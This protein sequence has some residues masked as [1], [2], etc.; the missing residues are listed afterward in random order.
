MIEDIIFWFSL[1]IWNFVYSVIALIIIYATYRVLMSFMLNRATKRELEAH[2]V[3]IMKLIVRII[4]ILVANTTVFQIFSLPINAI[5][6]GS[7]LIGAAIGFGSSQTINNI[8]AGFYVL[9]SQPFK[10]KDYVRIGSLEG[11]VEE[12]SINYTSL[13]TP[14]FNILKVPNTQ[15]MSSMVLNMTHEGYIKYTY[16]VNFDH[17]Y[18]E[19]TV[20]KKILEPAINDFHQFCGEGRLRCPEAYL[21]SADR[22]GKTYKIRLFIPKGEAKMLY[23]LQPELTQFIMKRFD[24]VRM[25]AE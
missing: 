2:I 4:F 23:T 18:S 17:T 24:E 1:N 13:Y 21:E 3:N 10:I 8:V 25:P 15:V 19:E 11:Q 12:I 7:A 16:N 14:T 22:L 6:G 20:F 5:L 9:I